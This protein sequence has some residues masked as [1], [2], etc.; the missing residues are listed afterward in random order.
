MVEP[1]VVVMEGR[2]AKDARQPTAAR[3]KERQ[4]IPYMVEHALPLAQCKPA[5]QLGQRHSESE[6]TRHSP[7]ALQQ[8]LDWMDGVRCPGKRRREDM[9]RLVKALVEHSVRVK[10]PVVA[11]ETHIIYQ[12][13][14][15]NF[16]Q[17]SR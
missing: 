10:Q 13:A 7:D 14:E 3:V 8:H 15:A 6:W 2:A 11:I 5:P 17:E 4:L 12:K 1:M 16:R 9:M